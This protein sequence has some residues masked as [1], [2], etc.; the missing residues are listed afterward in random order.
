MG[1]SKQGGDQRDDRGD[2]EVLGLAQLTLVTRLDIPANVFVE[3]GPPK[4]D[5]EVVSRSEYS[6]VSQLVV[7]QLNES[8][9]LR[10]FGD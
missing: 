6:F 3:E 9:T 8:V 5:Q 4:T 1:F 2:V 10:G 7:C